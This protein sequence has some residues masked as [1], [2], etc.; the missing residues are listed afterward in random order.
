MAWC[1]ARQRPGGWE[2]RA[3]AWREAYVASP[4]ASSSP[5]LCR[6]TGPARPLLLGSQENLEF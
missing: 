5:V 4:S 2:S 3:L 6:H 1:R